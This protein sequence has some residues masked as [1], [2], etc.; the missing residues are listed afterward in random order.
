[1]T[2]SEWWNTINDFNDLISWCRDN[3]MFEDEVENI[4]SDDSYDEYV[5]EDISNYYYGWRDLRD[6][7]DDL[8]Y[9]YDWYRVDGMFDYVALDDSDFEDIKQDICDRLE[10]RGYFVAE[11]DEDES[12]QENTELGSEEDELSEPD[13]QDWEINE[14]DNSVLSSML[15][16]IDTEEPQ[17][18]YTE[19]T[20]PAA[21]NPSEE[22]GDE[23]FD[24]AIE[25]ILF[26]ISSS[27]EAVA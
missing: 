14:L 10:D 12:S 5:N 15:E 19:E 13:D 24:E 25:R 6:A 26:G 16:D 3:E 9:G 27:G 18:E 21:T 20:D 11:E 8:P 4:I 22:Y 2:Q 23:A 7:L 17:E 1:M